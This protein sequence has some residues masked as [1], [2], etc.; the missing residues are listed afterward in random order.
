MNNQQ[1]LNVQNAV[2]LILTFNLFGKALGLLRE[3]VYANNF[4]LSS[5]YDLYL[6]TSIIPLTIST[7]LFYIVQNYFI[8]KYNSVKANNVEDINSFLI[9]VLIIFVVISIIISTILTYFC[10]GLLNL[11]LGNSIK[12]FNLIKKI[13]LIFLITI[14][15]N[16]IFSI[17][18]SY[19]QAEFEFKSPAIAQI[20]QNLFI[21]IC[22]IFLSAHI[23]IYS[24]AIGYMAGTLAQVIYL[25]LIIKKNFKIRINGFKNI[26]NLF[27][28]LTWSFIYIIIIESSSQLYLL[29]D[30]YFYDKV[31]NGGI[32]ALN[33]STNLYSLPIA[34]ITVTLATAIFPG[35]SELFSSNKIA[36]IYQKIIRF[37]NINVLLFLPIIFILYFWGYSII[38][39][40]FERGKFSN[41]D[42]LLTASTVKFYVLGLIPFSI[43]AGFNKLFYSF[44]WINKLLFITVLAVMIKIFF[45]Y[46]LVATL[47]QNGLALATSLSYMSL[48]VLTGIILLKEEKGL[49]ISYLIK[50]LL[51]YLI[52]TVV[53]FSIVIS[54]GDIFLNFNP[55]FNTLFKIILFLILYFLTLDKIADLEYLKIKAHILNLI[56]DFSFN[57]R[58]SRF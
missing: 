40:I 42:T 18:S 38:E 27:S 19:L 48:F 46:I 22:V 20:F 51:N 58:N 13:F 45:N 2:I 41:A 34:V 49:K 53:P 43:Y 3:V 11:Y 28:G 56:T 10:D 33:Y 47:K 36:E 15:I 5:D 57:I 9:K 24:I 30:R 16:V 44:G 25:Y 50:P 6:I 7:I 4:G 8:P 55:L 35:I 1:K 52:C 14:P 54:V 39:I 32:A 17:F 37:I 21:I 31:D 23:G 12:D 29:A 26:N